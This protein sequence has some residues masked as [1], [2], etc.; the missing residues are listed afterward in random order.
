MIASQRMEMIVQMVDAEGIKNIKDMAKAFDVTEMTIR[1]DCEELEKQGK[2]IR[3]RGGA[4]SVKKDRILSLH[5]EKPMA[6]R[7][8]HSAQKERVCERAAS[9]VKEGDCVFLDD[10]T[11]IA[12]M[13]KYLKGRRV[14]IVTTSTL[15]AN[16][17]D[18]D[19]SDLLLLGGLYMPKFN[20][21]TGPITLD[22]L[23]RFNF[24]YAFISCSGIDVVRDIIYSA[25]TDTTAVKVEAMKL[26]IK[27]YLLIDSSKLSI[28]GFYSFKHCGDFDAVICNSDENINEESL[29]D[30]FILTETNN[31]EN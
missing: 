12:P 5:D 7:T 4:K 8:E 24:D 27:K 21:V 30:N 18:D 25:D 19:T 16:L 28:K 1:R 14:K 10:G 29:P 13:V 9:F 23:R 22:A 26:A 31:I 11:S 20:A 15:I 3:V 17:F 2:L 6:E